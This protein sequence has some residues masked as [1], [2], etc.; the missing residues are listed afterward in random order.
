M[1]QGP[2]HLVEHGA[3]A[4]L[5]DRFSEIDEVVIESQ[6]PLTREIGTAFELMGLISEEVRNAI[7]DNAFPL[8]LAG[9]CNSTVGAMSGA[10][11]KNPGL[12]WFDAHGD[13]NTPETSSTGFLDGM[14][15]SMLRGQ[16]WRPMTDSIPDFQRVPD[17][18]IILIGAR[19]FDEVEISLLRSSNIALV[20]CDSI[21]KSGAKE[22]MTLGLDALSG[23]TKGVCIHVDMDV[24]NPELAP[25]NLFRPEGGL[26]PEEVRDTI[27]AVAERFLIYSVTIAAFDPDADH[28]HRGLNAGLELISLIGELV[29]KQNG[30]VSLLLKR[31]K[32]IYCH[33][34]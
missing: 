30:L 12:I 4:R 15:L 10:S 24:H 18:R 2:F 33:S 21:Q 32:S 19:D 8:I 7:L 20:P 9:N 14:A 28:E 34:I 1:G 16:C 26:S 6:D 22:A 29:S 13:I 27:S 3:V 25:S 17:D 23:K 5:R 31:L 11:S